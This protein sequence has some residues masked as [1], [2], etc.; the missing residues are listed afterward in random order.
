[1]HTE[2]GT[3]PDH[4][5]ST[6]SEGRGGVSR[7]AAN[8]WRK[9]LERS[10]GGGFLV[11]FFVGLGREGGEDGERDGFLGG[12]FE[13]GLGEG[14]ERGGSGVRGGGERRENGGE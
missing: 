12:G 5:A 10:V 2:V 6:S 14:G 11:G 1:M 9:G 8:E 4:S 13:M 3:E 7:G